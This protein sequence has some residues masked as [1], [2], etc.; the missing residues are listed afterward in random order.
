MIKKNNEQICRFINERHGELFVGKA[1][2][3]V[4]GGNILIIL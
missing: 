4:D 2:R 3:V 1:E